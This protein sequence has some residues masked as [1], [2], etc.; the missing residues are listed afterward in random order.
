MTEKLF[1]HWFYKGMIDISFSN[2]D[3][4]SSFKK[5]FFGMQLYSHTSQQNAFITFLQN[6]EPVKYLEYEPANKIFVAKDEPLRPWFD[7]ADIKVLFMNSFV[8]DKI[9]NLIQEYETDKDETLS[10][11]ELNLQKFAT[12]YG[13]VYNLIF[14]RKANELICE[15]GTK[16]TVKMKLKGVN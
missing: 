14:D 8:L 13:L 7:W 9:N 3:T 2:K 6:N 5:D 4:F 12:Y 1:L 16:Q 10:F 11:F 15:F